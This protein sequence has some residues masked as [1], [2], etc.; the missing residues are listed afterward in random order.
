[1]KIFR[2][3][4]IVLALLCLMYFITYLDRVNVSTA[5][6]GFGPEFKLTDITE[7][8]IDPK[9]LSSRKLPEGLTFD[10]PN[11]AKTSEIGRAHV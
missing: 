3:S 1:M 6:A 11:C 8:A 4:N 2:A 5:A 7:R 9:L 10:P